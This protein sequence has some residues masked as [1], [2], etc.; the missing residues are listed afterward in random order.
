M[1]VILESFFFFINYLCYIEL[2]GWC[3]KCYIIKVYLINVFK[4]LVLGENI[5]FLKIYIVCFN[6]K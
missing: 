6:N 1:F 5:I 4:F 3:Y 2:I